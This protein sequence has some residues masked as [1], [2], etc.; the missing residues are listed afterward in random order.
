M[1]IIKL[2][3]PS[4][5]KN[6]YRFSFFRYKPSDLFDFVEEDFEVIG[7]PLFYHKGDFTLCKKSQKASLSYKESECKICKKEGGIVYFFVVVDVKE[8]LE[9][10]KK[11]K[12]M[13]VVPPSEEIFK[14][15]ILLREKPD[16]LYKLNHL[17]KLGY[18]INPMELP[19]ILNIELSKNLTL[20]SVE[21]KNWALTPVEKKLVR[22]L[23]LSD[24]DLNKVLK[25][26][27]H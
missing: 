20:M 27:T 21:M 9:E 4:E 16:L 7:M 25:S 3:N 11:F 18:F 1:E 17:I 8:Y 2:V 23:D 10:Y 22:E 5:G 12:E 26:L 24:L 6:E 13:G 19:W 15:K 14:F